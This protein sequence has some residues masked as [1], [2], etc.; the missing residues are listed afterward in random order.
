LDSTVIGTPS[1]QPSFVV[2]SVSA[3]WRGSA[4]SASLTTWS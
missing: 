1:G 4:R 2:L 3:A